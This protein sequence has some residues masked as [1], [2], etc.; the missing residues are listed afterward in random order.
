[1]NEKQK[2]NIAGD[3][4]GFLER[5]QAMFE[6]TS[7]VGGELRL[8]YQRGEV[9]KVGDIIDSLTDELLAG[10][11]ESQQNIIDLRAIRRG[12]GVRGKREE[13]IIARQRELQAHYRGVIINEANLPN[14]AQLATI[15]QAKEKVTSMIEGSTSVDEALVNL[16]I[17]HIS[18]DDKK[19]YSFPHELMPES[20]NQKW[21]TYLASVCNHETLSSGPQDRDS[22]SRVEEADRIRKFAHD[23]VTSDV[24]TILNF[25]SLD[26]QWGFPQTRRLL[27]SIR[28]S[29]FPTVAAVSSPQAHQLVEARGVDLQV[30]KH[31]SDRR[32]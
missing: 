10:D 19:I 3:H 17:L 29:V 5:M 32:H 11:P 21:E 9:E 27:G 1:M 22:I 15:E 4:E 26:E 6:K 16:G 25:N 24:N 8:L 31:L 20:V 18:E 23:S 14:E 2:T 13:S 30:T 12:D 7:D 28:D